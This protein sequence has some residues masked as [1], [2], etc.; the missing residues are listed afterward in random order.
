MSHN[1]KFIFPTASSKCLSKFSKQVFSKFHFSASPC[2]FPPPRSLSL[3]FSLVLS[4]SLVLSRSLCLSLNQRT[5]GERERKSERG[6]GGEVSSASLVLFNLP[7]HV[8]QLVYTL[9]SSFPG[10]SSLYCFLL[11][12]I[13]CIY[14]LFFILPCYSHTFYSSSSNFTPLPSSISVFYHTDICL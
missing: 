11:L 1:G 2:F 9:F 10:H 5:N 7:F 13:F 3:S 6:Q 4:L 14:L 8:A 12:L